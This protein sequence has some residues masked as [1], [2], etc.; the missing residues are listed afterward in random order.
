MYCVVSNIVLLSSQTSSLSSSVW[1][2]MNTSPSTNWGSD[3]SSIWGDTNNSN[4]GFWDEAVKE[5]VQQ[6]PPTKKASTQKNNKGNANLRYLIRRPKITFVSHNLLHDWPCMDMSN[7][8]ILMTYFC[9]PPAFLCTREVTLW[10]GGS[11]R[12]PRRRRRS[13][14]SCLKGSIRAI[15]TPSC[16]GVSKP[17][18][19]STRPT[20]WMVRL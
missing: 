15:R 5:A 10:V 19:P 17:C 12:K 18:T 16:N 9:L 2:S 8:Q 11:I 13:W 4:L 14:W 7:T 20:I 3:S 6:P 1:G